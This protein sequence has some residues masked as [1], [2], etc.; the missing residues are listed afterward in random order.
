MSGIGRSTTFV[1]EII[2]GNATAPSKVYGD[3]YAFEAASAAVTEPRMRQNAADPAAA[4]FD[5]VDDVRV[6]AVG[7]TIRVFRSGKRGGTVT[8]WLHGGGLSALS[9]GLL[10]AEFQRRGSETEVVAPDLRGHGGTRIP[11]E[12]NI[13]VS[14]MAG[15]IVALLEELF[16]EVPPPIVLVGHSMGGALATHLA[17]SGLL[18][19]LI[20]VAAID[21]VEG[22][23]VAA[24][25]MM[26]E[27]VFRAQCPRSMSCCCVSCLRSHSRAF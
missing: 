25:P 16:G 24:L 18:P 20:G 1:P 11:D 3:P 22:T 17:A 9:F 14:T 19:T 5:T 12:K 10:A 26:Q 21:V 13:A 8:L 2:A 4:P 6:A 15:D 27:S 23:A 7:G